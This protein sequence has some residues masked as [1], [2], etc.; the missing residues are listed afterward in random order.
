MESHPQF[1]DPTTLCTVLKAL[2]YLGAFMA[3]VCLISDTME[4]LMLLRV[5]AGE[6]VSEDEALFNDLRQLLVVLAYLPLY[7]VTAVVF[8]RWVYVSNKNAHALGAPEM[9]HTPGWSVGW[10]FIPIANLWKPYQAVKETYQASHPGYYEDWQNAP[11][12]ALL[13]A[14][15]ALWI[16][17]S[18]LGQASFRVAMAGDT[19]ELWMASAGL[20]IATETLD[21]PLNLIVIA[22]V[23]QM[24][25]YQLE[26]QN[27]IASMPEPEPEPVDFDDM[28]QTQ[29]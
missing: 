7:I 20:A 11:A 1:R 28:L 9:K 6:Y 25:R 29:M 24:Q 21:V 10:F 4:L 17:T 18:I 22:L 23:S 3:V 14:W 27:L 26:K 2:L 15:W 5:Q 8:L 16:I 12:P 19:V 13:P